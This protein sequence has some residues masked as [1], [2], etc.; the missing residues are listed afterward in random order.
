[1]SKP[2]LILSDS[3][4][5]SFSQP[6]IH[7][8]IVEHFDVVYI[9]HN[10]T[11]RS[12][13]IVVT[14]V[15]NKNVSWY[16]NF[17]EQGRKIIIDN[18]WEMLGTKTN[19]TAHYLHNVNWFWYNESLWYTHLGYHNYRPNRIITKNGLLLMNIKKPHRNR[20]F[21]K[22]NLDNLLYSYVGNGVKITNDMDTSDN[23]WQRYFSP[24]WY[25]STAFSIVAET[26]IEKNKSLLITEKTFKPM[27]FYHPFIVWGQPGVLSHLQ[28]LGFET[29][30][31]IFNETY[32]NITDPM[33]RLLCIVDQINNYCH[34]SHDSLTLQKLE[35][36]NK[37][38]FDTHLVKSKIIK[39]IVEP[40]L[41]YAET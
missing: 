18:L 19:Q 29:F 17:L 8:I 12:N 27:A 34:E 24:N 9:E 5:V 36:N 1:M 30:M 15:L 7:D 39:E 33:S 16:Q 38:F 31:N 40:I 14:N 22:L 35:H 21:N 41:E 26:T 28:N 32:D 25:N 13:G 20:L 37:L 2:Q 3:D 4:C 10:P 11:I 6:W 23:N